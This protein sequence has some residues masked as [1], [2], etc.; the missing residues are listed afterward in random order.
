MNQTRA[1]NND[2][3]P[4]GIANN[5]PLLDSRQYEGEFLA[6]SVEILTANTITENFLGQVDKESHQQK[7]LAEIIDHWADNNAVSK[8][9]GFF[10]TRNGIQE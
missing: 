2:G 1:I 6:D 10:Y 4:I 3:K 7:M 8:D 9:N 5:N